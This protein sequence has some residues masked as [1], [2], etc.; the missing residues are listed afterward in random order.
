MLLYRLKCVRPLAR[1]IENRDDDV[2]TFRTDRWT[3]RLGLNRAK[4]AIEIIL[5]TE[6]EWK[7]YEMFRARGL[8]FR[9]VA[10]RVRLDNTD[11]PAGRAWFVLP[12]LGKLRYDGANGFQ[13]VDPT[14]GNTSCHTLSEIIPLLGCQAPSKGNDTTTNAD[15]TG[16]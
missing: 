6:P 2:T 8:T 1:P 3:S 7:L 5:E 13:V 9:L 14:S 12:H 4:T 16:F 15:E 10:D 11:S